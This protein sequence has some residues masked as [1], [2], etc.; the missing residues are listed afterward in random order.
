MRN[1]T[2][3]KTVPTGIRPA[4]IEAPR[5]R[6]GSFE[7]V[8]VPKP[9]RRLD[10]TDQIVPSLSAPGLT[11]GAVAAHFEEAYAAKASTD[12]ISEDH[13]ESRRG[14]GR[15]DRPPAGT[16]LPGDLRR[17][18]DQIRAAVRYATPPS[19]SPWT[20]PPSWERKTPPPGAGDGPGG[21]RFRL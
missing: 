18:A 20:S 15:V 13:R 3:S 10:E 11:A 17:C 8:N 14:A 7:P 2:R 1:G 5:D 4:E 6:E 12:T 19:P 9:K 21:P 16:D